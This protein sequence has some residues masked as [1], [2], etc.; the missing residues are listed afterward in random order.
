MT[1]RYTKAVLTVIALCLL[2]LAADSLSA[3][4]P[5]ARAQ[6]TPPQRRCVWTTVVERGRPTLGENGEVKLG[7]EFQPVSEG[8]A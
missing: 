7:R 8:L 3:R 6:T 5:V 4:L 2:V 1:D